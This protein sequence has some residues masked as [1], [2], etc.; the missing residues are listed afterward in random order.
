M[1]PVTIEES[2]PLNRILK[3]FPKARKD[4]VDKLLAAKY[5]TSLKSIQE[6]VH[7][8]LTNGYDEVEEVVVEDKGE[9]FCPKVEHDMISD[10]DSEFISIEENGNEKENENE[11]CSE[12]RSENIVPDER[13]PGDERQAS[14]QIQRIDDCLAEQ[15]AEQAS[16]ARAKRSALRDT[17]ADETIIYIIMKRSYI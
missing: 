15:Y 11:I 4:Y 17:G 1:R 8:M 2:S 12:D 7:D 13:M 6:I 14:L 5:D 10:D 9:N 16:A 3:L